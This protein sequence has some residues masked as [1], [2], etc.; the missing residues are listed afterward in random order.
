MYC[1]NSLVI[2]IFYLIFCEGSYFKIVCFCLED[3]RDVEVVSGYKI[4]VCI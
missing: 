2:I 3:S 4:I 1:E